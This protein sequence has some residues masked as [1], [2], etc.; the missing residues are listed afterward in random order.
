MKDDR[1][2]RDKGL[3][4]PGSGAFECLGHVDGRR[5]VRIQ[6]TL[7]LEVTLARGAIVME[8]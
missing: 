4:A 7:A 3:A 8:W 2:T 1:R 6:I 5:E